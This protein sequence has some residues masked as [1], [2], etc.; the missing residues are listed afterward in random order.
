MRFV[1]FL[2]IPLVSL[3]AL[4]EKPWL[5]D[6]YSFELYTDFA[7]SR[8]QTINHAVQ[9]PAYPYH[10]Y[11][12][13]VAISFTPSPQIDAEVEVNLARTPHQTYGFRSAAIQA[14]YLVLD[15]IAG[16]P[17]SLVLGGNMRGVTARAVRDVSC[18]YGSY[19]N[20]EVTLF[21]GKETSHEGDWLY[22]WYVGG[23][24]LGVANHGLPWNRYLTAFE[25]RFS[26]HALKVFSLGYFGY[27]KHKKVSIDHFH[28]WA[29]IHHSSI[30]I[31][32][33]Y[34]YEF[35]LYGELGLSYAYRLW[36]RSYPERE[37][38]LV[39][40]YTLPFSLF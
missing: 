3:S 12:T 8:Y 11:V 27:G 37:Q 20:A 6:P 38:T 4:Q 15:D 23:A 13:D 16:D 14:R 19:L 17:I 9:Q 39:L 33:Q 25:T 18:P 28:G 21:L 30:D 36:A 35:F 2:G 5:A 22:R 24:L 29:P 34:R 31:G 7:Y 26:R 32:A 40:S 1:F 10:N